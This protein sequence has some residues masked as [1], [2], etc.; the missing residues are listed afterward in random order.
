[1]YR[2]ARYDRR[3]IL[4]KDGHGDFQTPFDTEAAE[5]KDFAPEELLRQ[6]LALPSLPEREVVKHYV[7]LSQMTYSID[8]GMYPLGSCTMKF[9]PKYAD[10]LASLPTVQDIHPCQDEESV[11][12]A[13]RLLHELE[14]ALCEIAGM[15]AVTLQPAAGAHG[16]LTGMLLTKAYH[17][18]AGEDRTEVVVPDSAHGTNPASAAM[19]GFQVIEIPSSKEGRVDIEALKAAV[20]R[21]TAAFMITNPNTHG[22][23]ESD[24]QEIAGVVHDAGALLYYDG[25]NLNA[26]MGRTTPGKMDFDIVH[27]N[28]HK[29]FATPHGG[30]GPGAGPVGVKKSVEPFLPIPRIVER[31]VCA[32]GVT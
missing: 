25:A 8:N 13:L 11:Q 6:D 32:N 20:T 15:D 14:L 18:K 22:L 27:F 5:L 7:N 21:K 23:F 17:R 4:E 16:E 12:G 30:G 19:A 24:I 29:T 2:Q 28:L 31:N 26:V 1:M 9:N 3:L 10:V